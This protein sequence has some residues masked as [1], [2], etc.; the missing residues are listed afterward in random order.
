VTVA[1]VGVSHTVPMESSS[2][3]IT[4][5]V[6]AT[7]VSSEAL[8]AALGVDDVD[9]V[10]TTDVGGA[11]DCV[12]AGAPDVVVIGTDDESLGVGGRIAAIA[13]ATRI[14]AVGTAEPAA[15]VDAGVGALV[16]DD[17][18]DVE[19][20]SAVVGLARGEARIDA[21]MASFLIE[22]VAQS[23]SIEPLSDTEVEVL[24]HLAAGDDV[25]GLASSHAV[26]PRIVRVITG[27]V[28]ARVQLA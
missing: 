14:A 28:L 8:V 4:V 9:V 11:V 1:P 18:V 27:G 12:T 7:G 19:L 5:V 17:A 23:D 26:S 6:V 22:H 13:P 20:A 3:P 24:N 25:D 15:L 16:A 2:S 10:A 21:G